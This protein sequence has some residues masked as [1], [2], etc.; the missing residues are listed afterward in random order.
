M[1]REVISR[2][3]LVLLVVVCLGC[4]RDEDSASSVLSPEAMIKASDEINQSVNAPQK[5][6]Q[7]FSEKANSY[8]KDWLRARGESGMV[9]D[10][11][12]LG[13][14]GNPFRLRYSLEYYTL[15]PSPRDDFTVDTQF[16]FVFGDG[17]ELTEIFNGYGKTFELA[18]ENAL[19][20][21]SSS[22]LG[23]LYKAFI[24][25]NDLHQKVDN[26]V[27]NGQPRKLIAGQMI[28]RSESEDPM[29]LFSLPDNMETILADIELDQNKHLI[30]VQYSQVIDEPVVRITIDGVISELLIDRVAALD[31][32][33]PAGL[34]VCKQYLL[35]E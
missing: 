6:K 12:G 8:L 18:I 4:K 5:P 32:P 14:T 2:I 3:L 30:K 22:T 10:D 16:V 31:W 20:N 35:V 13:I 11:E 33:K 9:L 7:L 26:V 28:V 27:I 1:K 17:R 23:V 19:V 24:N 25:P 21:F 34:M 29:A 15:P